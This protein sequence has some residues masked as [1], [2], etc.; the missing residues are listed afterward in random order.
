MVNS[1]QKL[2]QHCFL[3]IIN[4]KRF[5]LSAKNLFQTIHLGWLYFYDLFPETFAGKANFRLVSSA[6]GLDLGI[7][8]EVH[9]AKILSKSVHYWELKFIIHTHTR[10]HILKIS[11]LGIWTLWSMFSV[12]FT[13]F[14]IFLFSWRLSNICS[15]Y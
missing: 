12:E 9:Y 6:I 11:F 7:Y 1:V 15:K 13:N 5:I 8:T 10:T 2:G 14:V 3:F 4:R